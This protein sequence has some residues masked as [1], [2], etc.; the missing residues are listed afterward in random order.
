METHNVPTVPE[1]EPEA[2]TDESKNDAITAGGDL[3]LAV[4]IG[5]LELG[6]ADF[7]EG[8]GGFTGLRYNGQEYKRIQLRRAMPDRYPSEYISV[9]DHE[10]KEIGMIRA[11]TDL[12]DDQLRIVSDELNRRYYCPEILE[13]KSVRDKLGYVYMEMDVIAGGERHERS[14][15]VN[16]V[17]KNIRMIGANRLI[18][19]DVDGNR[20]IVNALDKLD[21]KSL[22]RLEPYMF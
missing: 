21:R 20:F 1:P 2:T 4:D 18:V 22:R 10:H 8:N 7:Y 15:A 16:D 6:K 14:A 17:N 5:W 3:S 9:A 19:F 11:L 13:I 12:S